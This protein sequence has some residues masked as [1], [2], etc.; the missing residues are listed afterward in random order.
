[1]SR[2]VEIARANPGLAFVFWDSTSAAQAGLDLQAAGY[3]IQLV[4]EGDGETQMRVYI[5]TFTPAVLGLN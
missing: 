4:P 5:V 1:M 3:D 2:V